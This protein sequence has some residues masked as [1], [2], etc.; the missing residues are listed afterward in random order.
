MTAAVETRLARW[1]LVL[2]V[3]ADDALG[4][5]DADRATDA[6]TDAA[7]DA[8]LAFLYDR[9]RDAVRNV[10]RRPAAQQ[11]GADLGPSD[12][13]VPAWIA[14]VHELF[15]RRVAERIE[16]DALERYELLAL[17]TDPAVLA[18]AVPSVALLK[19]ILTTRHLMAPEVLAQARQIV[20]VVVDEL[21]RS[22]AAPV[23]SALQGARDPRTRSRRRVA[24]NFDAAATVRAN[25]D[26]WDPQAR[27]L[28]IARPLFAARTRPHTDRWQ[29]VVLVDQ[30]GSMADNVIHAA[31]TASIFA[32]L[33]NL[34]RTHLIAFDTEVVDLTHACDDPTEVLMRVQ[35][36]G[37]T[38][39]ARAVRHAA[40][41]LEQPRR[42]I[43]V[44]ISDFC[45]GGSEGDLIAA[46]HTLV[47]DGATVLALGALSTDA[48]PAYDE[49]IARRLAD[50]GADVGA[51]TPGELAEWVAERVSA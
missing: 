19:A 47:E 11:L 22:L 39:I 27:R 29:V 9:E 42:S 35:L 30:S 3:E 51:M 4:V 5:A 6:A 17:V 31:V 7:R 18:R 48:R 44:L 41:L 10:R 24:A 23:A 46:V 16:R 45:E 15:P 38:D 26:R 8:A 28:G 49:R 1:R 32:E 21:R 34:M 12:P 43:V 14:S 25:L 13:Y 40:T 37:G 36:G 33:G 2:G 50:A 20:R